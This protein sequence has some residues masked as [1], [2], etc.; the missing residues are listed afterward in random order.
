MIKL[1]LEE[2]QSVAQYIHS[3]C[4]ITLDQSKD[5]LIE[6]RLA[7]VMVDTGSTSFTQLLSRA[8]T[9]SA[10]K[11]KIIDEITTNETLFFRDSSPFDLLRFKIIPE[12]IDRRTKSGQTVPI[13]IWSAACSTGQELYSIA[14]VLRELLGD[15]RGYNIRLVGTD[16][17]DQAV[18]RASEGIF[19]QIEVDRGLS[20]EAR[21]K[22]FVAHPKG[23]K[24]RD[25][26]RA[27]ASFRKLNL[28]EDFSALGT[29]D[30]IFCRNVAIYFNDRDRISLFNRIEQRLGPGGCLV[31]GSM[32]SLSAISPQ[33]ESKRHLRSVY[34]EVK[35]AVAA[36]TGT[37][38]ASR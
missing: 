9:D 16:I 35:S 24:I 11:R 31:I 34:Y 36:R 28:M 33:F 1:L 7:S 8:R 19:S 32:E 14:I 37:G 38:L 30:V 29:F 15:M 2:R 12:L 4:A 22:S 13:R 23:W 6:S 25:E 27:M 18:T 20:R 21:D 17:S 10:V 26:L 5:Y 3:I